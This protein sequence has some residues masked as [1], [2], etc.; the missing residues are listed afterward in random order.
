M[1]GFITTLIILLLLGAAAY[2]SIK[3]NYFIED[4]EI[5]LEAAKKEADLSGRGRYVIARMGKTTNN[6]WHTVKDEKGNSVDKIFTLI[7]DDPSKIPFVG[8]NNDAYYKLTPM[9]CK[10]NKIVFFI[11]DVKKYSADG[12][13][14]LDYVVTGW[15][16]L[17]PV[18]HKESIF[19]SIGEHVDIK[20]C[21]K[22][23]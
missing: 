14:H 13:E 23:P 7:G 19:Y 2:P 4:N 5:V 22:E 16:V 18:W 3:R 11:D 21:V 20:D 9:F 1:R 17:F 6:E 15:T 8:K 10:S 12:K